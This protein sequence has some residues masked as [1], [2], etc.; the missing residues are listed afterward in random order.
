MFAALEAKVREYLG[1]DILYNPIS[2]EGDEETLLSIDYCPANIEL[3]KGKYEI[4]HLDCI[5]ED[6][7]TQAKAHELCHL[8]LKS[9]GLFEIQYNVEEYDNLVTTLNNSISHRFVIDVLR[10]EFN[11]DSEYFISIQKNNFDILCKQNCFCNSISSINYALSLFDIERCI[12]ELFD[13]VNHEAQKM[14]VIALALRQA[15]DNLAQIKPSQSKEEQKGL[16]K[17]FL[18]AILIPYQFILN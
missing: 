15:R 11:L 6:K 2:H 3:D 1:Y 12:P 16:I 13:E 7:I 5:S 14:D 9:I 8:Y 18:N 17:T 4:N 10:D